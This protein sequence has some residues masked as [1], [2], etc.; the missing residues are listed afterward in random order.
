MGSPRTRL[1]KYQLLGGLVGNIVSLDTALTMRRIMP[2]SRID[3]R[4]FSVQLRNLLI[5]DY[6]IQ[7]YNA[8]YFRI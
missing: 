4:L 1:P 2:V 8:V 7:V 6:R 3:P 5:A